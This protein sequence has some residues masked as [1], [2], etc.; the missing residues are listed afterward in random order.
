MFAQTKLFATARLRLVNADIPSCDYVDARAPRASHARRIGR[1]IGA[2]DA[3]KPNC[4]WEI[5]EI[6]G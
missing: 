1:P 6:G 4:F 5:N 2:P 3:Q